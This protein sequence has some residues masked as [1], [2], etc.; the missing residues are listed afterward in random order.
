MIVA[1][2]LPE[3]AVDHIGTRLDAGIENTASSMAKLST[4]I[5]RPH[6]ERLKCVRGR[7]DDIT[8]AIQEVCKIHVVIDT[9]QDEAVLFSALPVGREIPF[10]LAAR[11]LGS[12]HDAHRQLRDID[13][14]PS[15]ERRI[16]D[17]LSRKS[18]PHGRLLR[19]HQLVCAV[20]LNCLRY[21]TKPPSAP[22]E[23]PA[24]EKPHGIL[25][26]IIANPTPTLP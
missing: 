12:R 21:D 26:S 4:V 14:V 20:H 22:R 9:I 2:E 18:L 8:G 11:S 3:R 5:G 19:L 7:L 25:F 16:F 10:L 15:I 1:E 24:P 17:G 13:V 6:A 23:I